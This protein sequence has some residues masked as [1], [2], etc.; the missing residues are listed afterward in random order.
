MQDF[1]RGTY[2]LFL[3]LY[4]AS[5]FCHFPAVEKRRCKICLREARRSPIW[6]LCLNR[7]VQVVTALRVGEEVD[8]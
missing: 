5:I 3:R 8:L 7:G 1:I 6:E 4:P 2:Y